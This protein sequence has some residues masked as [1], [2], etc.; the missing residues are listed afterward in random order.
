MSLA[1]IMTSSATLTEKESLAA[2]F[3]RLARNQN[4]TGALVI[5]SLAAGTINPASD[6]DLVI[7]LNA[8]PRPWFVGITTIDNRP[9]DLIFVST[10]AVQAVAAL[11]APVSQD[12]ELA[13]VIRWL[14]TGDIRFDRHGDL[15]R[16]QKRLKQ[17]DWIQA[18][19]D[20][21][22]YDAWF[23]LN[24]NLAVAERLAKSEAELYRRTALIRMGVYGHTDIWF[25]Y[26]TIRKLP[27]AGDKAAVNHLL[28]NDREF[29]TMF[30][31][32]L[33]ASTIAEK[34]RLYRQVAQLAAAPHG[35]LWPPGATVM[36]DDR[37]K[38]LWQELM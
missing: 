14:S 3:E 1:Q 28:A 2:V 30:Q 37:A 27:W 15:G 33:A 29:M 32:F 17:G 12:H 36:N 4:V 23:A 7:V 13:P 11:T 9:T 38:T 20:K 25:G 19:D 21:A 35:G 16:L 5:G 31:R 10:T 18:I 34:L 6:Y 8:T 22:G 24:Y 26:F